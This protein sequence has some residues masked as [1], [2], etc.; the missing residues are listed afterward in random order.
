MTTVPD[1][2]VEL[3]DAVAATA[4]VVRWN[5]MATLPSTRR[6]TKVGEFG[7]QIVADP[8]GVVALAG[9]HV[10]ALDTVG[11]LEDQRSVA[12]ALVLRLGSWIEASQPVE[13]I[14]TVRVESD[15]ALLREALARADWSAADPLTFGLDIAL[16]L[17]RAYE[18]AISLKW[19]DM[20]AAR[21]PDIDAAVQRHRADFERRVG[22]LLLGMLA[23]DPHAATEGR[24]PGD[25]AVE[26]LLAAEGVAGA[27]AT[28]LARRRLAG[29]APSA[30]LSCGR[31][32]TITAP[33]ELRN[34][35]ELEVGVAAL[36]NV[37][38][39]AERRYQGV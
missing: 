18:Q 3:T 16:S 5:V 25:A 2:M 23:N 29:L 20:R 38:W 33:D 30:V 36:A 10:V 13:R 32:S 24:P 34:E 14:D 28:R 27:D 37:R 26:F 21:E 9:M 1:S 7:I 12:D 8:S 31:V 22:R 35:N 39:S 6:T 19:P 11:T 17:R 4:E 15:S